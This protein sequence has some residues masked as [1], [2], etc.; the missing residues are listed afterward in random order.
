MI[1]F[2]GLYQLALLVI[3]CLGY[4]VIILADRQKGGLRFLGNVIGGVIIGLS[5]L[6]LIGDL[7]LRVVL[8]SSYTNVPKTGYHGSIHKRMMTPHAMPK[9]PVQKP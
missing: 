1:G 6:Y 9:V 8:H 3:L 4:G 5:I 2:L 7:W